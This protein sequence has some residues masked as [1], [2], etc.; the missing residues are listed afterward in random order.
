[1]KLCQ[2]IGLLGALPLLLFFYFPLLKL[3]SDGILG[4]SG[5]FSYL[6][7]EFWRLV[8]FTYGQAILSTVL[9][10][11]VGTALALV[12]SDWEFLGKKVIWTLSLL[13]FVLPAIIV[14]NAMVL[15]W[16]A[17]SVFSRPLNVLGISSFAYGISGILLCHVFMNFPLFLK[18][19]TLALRENGRSEEMSAMS[20]G[21]SRLRTLILITLPK[22]GATLLHT[23]LLS[24]VLCSSSFMV[25]LLLGGGPR[26]S[27]LEVAIYQ[28]VKVEL[29]IPLA[30][31]LAVFQIAVGVLL[32]GVLSRV[33]RTRVPMQSHWT[34]IFA[35]RSSRNR[36]LGL[37]IAW[38]TFIVLVVGPLGTLALDG[39]F[40]SPTLDWESLANAM[41]GS[42]ALAVRTATFSL[43]AALCLAYAARHGSDRRRRVIEVFSTLP[44][45]ISS[46]LLSLAWMVTYRDW[47]FD[48]R[49]DPNLIAL[50]QSIGVLPMVFRVIADALTRIPD[51]TIHSAQS[52][53][54]SGMQIFWWVELKSLRASLFLGLSL[55]IGYSIGEVGSQLMLLDEH[56][57]TLPLLIYRLM[58]RYQFS[59]SGFV[60]AILLLFLAVIFA[61][62]QRVET[63][64]AQ[65]WT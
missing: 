35:P 63:R 20:L 21:A 14:V 16:G 62:S 2:V 39:L 36:R 53:G 15:T 10:C 48:H 26:Y 12:S 19:M 44:I 13:G 27:T 55:A 43:T 1:M 45:V 41:G 37:L 49:G 32:F 17:S 50:V 7:P 42:L 64:R 59:E 8:C 52:L 3:L 57:L 34:P 11:V 56:L 4:S 9:S 31:R 22:T 46:I 25:V 24:F 23:G 38:V 29:D 58:A 47:F 65:R 6:S 61:I 5:A 33:G 18:N 54:A 30:C 60:S 40:Q 51:E 28:A